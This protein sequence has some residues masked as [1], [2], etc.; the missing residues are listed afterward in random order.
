MTA[1]RGVTV[2]RGV[3]ARAA[4]TRGAAAVPRAL[5]GRACRLAAMR[6]GSPVLVPALACA[7]VAALA[8]PAAAG[9]LACPLT[10]P[11]VVEVDGML[12]DWS[13]VAP[14]RAGGK[15]RDQSL[16]VRCSFDGARLAIAIDVRD[17][18]LVRLYKPTGKKLEGEDRLEVTLGAGADAPVVRLRPGTERHAP[19]REQLVGGKPRPAPRWLVVEDS[20][21]KAGWA[22]ELELPLAQLPGWSAGAAELPIALTFHD[23]DDTEVHVSTP[24]S[25]RVEL[26]LG[27]RPA[28]L[29]R[30]LADLRLRPSD[31]V[32]DEQ[33]DIDRGH[34]GSER[35]VVA[36]T[37]LA[38]VTDR[39]G[40]VT[41]PVADAED[42]RA[43]QLA[44]LRGDGS[45][46]VVAV[47]RQHGGIGSRDL[48]TAWQAT[49]GQLEQV[50]AVEVGK[51]A[52][53]NRLTSA[54]SLV[55]AGSRRDAVAG[56]GKGKAGSKPG[57]GKPRGKGKP[58]RAGSELVIE[59]Q[60]AVGWDEDTYEEDRAD[61][62][63]P[64]HLPWDAARAGAVYWLDGD[65]VRSVPLPAPA[66]R[67]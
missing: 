23:A 39:Y 64:V 56:K 55:P 8:A 32:L 6:A 58:A 20:Q 9:T 3:T 33:A 60:P 44:D 54:W 51:Q 21:Q 45:R 29:S 19:Q 2:R 35:V 53:A 12:D 50:L 49:D 15:D 67:R 36:G 47:L 42:V 65:T 31:V 27:E 43:V 37:A 28:L 61:D 11:G 26:G 14:A 57:K 48:L 18:R 16:D 4:P 46:V 34:P 62:A 5:G 41:L 22:V 38:I 40:Y 17:D 59:A 30:L 7:A 52:G 25:H 66:A 63:E 10:E 1:R 13:G 24:L